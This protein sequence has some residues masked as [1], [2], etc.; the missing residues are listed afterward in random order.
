MRWP[1]RALAWLVLGALAWV[2][3]WGAVDPPGGPYMAAEWW[4]RGGLEH[5]WRD[6][7]RIS[8][9]LARAVIAAEDA[10]FCDHWGI[11]LAAVREAVAEGGR[12]RG[13]STIT[14]QLA[15]NLFLWQG[16]SWLRKGLEAG[17]ALLLEALWSKR[18]ILEVYLNVVEFGRGVFGAEAA[19]RHWF[20]RPAAGLTLEQ[21]ARLAAIL[22]DPQHRDPRRTTPYMAR[23][24]AA[25]IAGARTIA[26]EGRDSCVLS[27]SGAGGKPHRRS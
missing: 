18:R 12:L 17:F 11:D 4:R 7:D 14:Q 6:L 16:R 13:A 24:V 20:A 5:E 1:L 19:A 23:R 25:I 10:R 3:L 2:A 21:A 27:A 22:P 9:H 26:A 8:P 15:K